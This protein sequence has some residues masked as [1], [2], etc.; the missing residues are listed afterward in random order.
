MK[1]AISTIKTDRIEV[2]GESALGLVTL[3]RPEEMNPLDWST[4]KD[5]GGVLDSL[6]DDESIRV[7]ASPS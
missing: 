7:I 3:N 1:E 6:A 5:L 4:V 2:D